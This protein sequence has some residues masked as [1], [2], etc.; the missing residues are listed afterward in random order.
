MI[1]D[2]A[3]LYLLALAHGVL[4]DG[5]NAVEM[6]LSIVLVAFLLAGIFFGCRLLA[7]VAAPRL[8][9]IS[10]VY[11]LVLV[12]LVVIVFGWVTDS[13]GYSL[14]VGGFFAGLGDG[15]GY[16]P[17]RARIIEQLDGLVIVLVPFFFVLIGAKAEWNVLVDTGMATLLAG[18]LLVALMGKSLGGVLGAVGERNFLNRM[19]IG[20]SM[21]PRGEVAL[22]IASI[23]FQQE[24]ISHHVLVALILMTIGAAVLAPL[25]IVPLARY[26]GARMNKIS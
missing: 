25:M 4:T 16:G 15:L 26:H 24:H 14:V 2:V 9:A 21:A 20:V 17:V 23:G 19:L 8:S 6:T 13:M 10:P 5:V 11:R 18:L 7:R 22:V 1:D 12:I 3:A